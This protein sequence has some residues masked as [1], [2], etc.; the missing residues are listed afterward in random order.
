MT[1][2]NLWLFDLEG[3]AVHGDSLQ[4]EVHQA[5]YIRPTSKGGDVREPSDNEALVEDFSRGAD[6]IAPASVR[7]SSAD[8]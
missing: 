3:Y 4:M 2:L 1:A 5:W 6:Y 8:R 7:R